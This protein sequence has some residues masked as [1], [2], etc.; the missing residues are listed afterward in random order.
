MRITLELEP[1][2]LK[3]LD[4][5][6]A[7]YM[8]TN[9]PPNQYTWLQTP[10]GRK[11]FLLVAHSHEWRKKPIEEVNAYVKQQYRDAVGYAQMGRPA[12][13]KAR[14]LALEALLNGAPK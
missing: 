9:K 1:E 4:T 12:I 13:A 3:K 11:V 8:V 14:A 6:A 2:L 10:E 7:K 5:L